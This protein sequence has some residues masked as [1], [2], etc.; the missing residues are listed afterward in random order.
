MARRPPGAER[1]INVMVALSLSETAILEREMV[2]LGVR[3]RAVLLR[4]AMLYVAGDAERA[5]RSLPHIA[6]RRRLKRDL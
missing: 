6:R 3:Q 1:T 4:W 5:A 2:R